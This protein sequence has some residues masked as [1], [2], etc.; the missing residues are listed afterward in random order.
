MK[1]VLSLLMVLILA[2]LSIKCGSSSELAGVAINKIHLEGEYAE[3]LNAD[4][5]KAL[6]A[7]GATLNQ[8]G[9][10]DLNGTVTWEWAGDEENPY[11]TVV[12]V[13]M[14]SEPKEANLTLTNIFN[15][16]RVRNGN[17]AAIFGN[18]A[19]LEVP[20]SWNFTVFHSEGIPVA[21][22]VDDAIDLAGLAIALLGREISPIGQIGYR[23]GDVR[24]PG[25]H[26]PGNTLLPGP[27]AL[28]AFHQAQ[29]VMRRDNAQH[30]K[31][32]PRQSAVAKAAKRHCPAAHVM[33]LSHQPPPCRS[34]RGGCLVFPRLWG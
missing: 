28:P 6:A 2:G 14:Q 8:S 22:G 1:R 20:T 4:L 19:A 24:F 13:F 30:P 23:L 25:S 15:E 34:G 31:V 17:F 26:R 10:P 21:G 3:D 27:A 33:L 7:A 18:F 16:L 11:P 9:Q 5:E 29:P 12:R 32:Q